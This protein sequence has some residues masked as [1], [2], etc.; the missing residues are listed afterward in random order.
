MRALV[1]AAALACV[2][3]SVAAAVVAACP[4]GTQCESDADSTHAIIVRQA[5]GALRDG[6][7]NEAADLWR[8]ALL[9]DDRVAE[10]W[11]ALG[12]ALTGAGR[13]REAVAA[14]QR[15]IQLDAGQRRD[16]TWRI[17]RAYALMGHD[18]QALRWME[19]ALRE[20]LQGSEREWKDPLFD[21]FRGEVRI[22]RLM[23]TSDVVDRARQARAGTRR[24]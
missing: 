11:T 4:A 21:R 20:G 7:W 13:H 24:S 22:R 8:N 19:L 1:L 3:P 6:A 9:M 17:A 16:A 5:R 23:D 12:R 10:H 2:T 18:K 14:Y 15:S